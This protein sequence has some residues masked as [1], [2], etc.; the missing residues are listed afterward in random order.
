MNTCGT[1][2]LALFACSVAVPVA[3]QEASEQPISRYVADLRVALPKVPANEDL[4]SPYGISSTNLPGFGLGADFAAHVY[5]IRLKAVT[6]GVGVGAV[7]G[8]AH[9]GPARQKDGTLVGKDVTARFFAVAPQ[10]SI[11]FGSSAGWSYLSGGLGSA[12]LEI[13]TPD[14]PTG[15]TWPRRKMLNYGGGGRW[16][17]RNHAAVTFDIRF[18]GINPVA[19]TAT[20]FQAPRLRIL[21]IS[22]GMSFR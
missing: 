3:A 22:V 14:T 10:I 11:N 13:Q 8:H 16:F 20:V 6:F 12:T 1:V 19:Q 15:T 5:P 17:V 7:F 4:A 2:A 9:A 18:Y 21:V